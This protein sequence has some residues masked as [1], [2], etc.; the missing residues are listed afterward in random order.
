MF[1]DWWSSFLAVACVVKPLS[2]QGGDGK[3]RLNIEEEYMLRFNFCRS[4]CRSYQVEYP[5]V[6]MA[7]W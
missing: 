6:S 3:T 7:I 4:F 5:V 1:H 2:T